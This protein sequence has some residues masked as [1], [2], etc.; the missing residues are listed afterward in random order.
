M[1]AGTDS[2]AFAAAAGS[3]AAPYVRIVRHP[4]SDYSYGPSA[5]DAAYVRTD[6]TVIY[7][8][9]VDSIAADTTSGA[10]PGFIPVEVSD[11]IRQAQADSLAAI[12]S[13]PPSGAREGLKPMENSSATG[14][15]L[16]ALMMG[17]LLLAAFCSDGLRRALKTYRHEL[18]G[19]R[20]RP[21]VFDEGH[22]ASFSMT[23]VLMLIYVVF[24]GLVVYNLPGPAE[25]TGFAGATAA[26]G[27]LAAYTIF[28]FAAYETVGYAF[29][30][31]EDRRK[32]VDG[33]VASESFAGLALTVPA[34]LMV[35]RPELYWILLIISLS[36]ESISRLLFII[37]GLRIFYTGIGSLLYFILYLCTLEVI[38]CC[39]VYVLSTYLR[40]L[41]A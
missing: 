16:I 25:S 30:R 32:W 10:I 40:D 7:T 12:A 37:K 22:T 17:T 29:G 28:R 15:P 38:P 34:I 19:V 18:L 13:I 2:T 26:M 6:T 11:S 21:N 31:A 8:S 20:R 41:S 3:A 35:F 23:M 27:L 39:A 5:D 14:T 36:V 1:A 33:F 4:Q 9:I 24:G